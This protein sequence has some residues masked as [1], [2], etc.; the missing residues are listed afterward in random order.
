MNTIKLWYLKRYIKKKTFA[1]ANTLKMTIIIDMLFKLV[2]YLLSTPNFRKFKLYSQ[3]QSQLIDHIFKADTHLKVIY[4]IV[5]FFY[6]TLGNFCF[7]IPLLKVGVT[8]FQSLIEMH[9]L[10]SYSAKS[11]QSDSLESDEPI[12]SD[13]FDEIIVG[14]G[15]GGSI[16]ALEAIKVGRKTLLIELGSKIDPQISHQTLE[17]LVRYFLY[18]GQE[19]AFGNRLIAYAQ[20]SVLGGGSEINSGLYHKLPKKIMLRWLEGLNIES[21]AWTEAEK[22]I[23]KLL[24]VEEQDNSTLNC[25]ISSPFISIAKNNGWD[26]MLVPRWRHYGKKGFVHFGMNSAVLQASKA[27]GLKILT[28]HKVSKF[29]LVDNKVK[30]TLDHG[31]EIKILHASYLTIACG[32]TET[33]KLLIKSGFAKPRDFSFNFHAMTRL[34]ALFSRKV[35]DLKDIDPHQ[36]WKQDY[37]VKFGAAVGTKEFLAATLSNFHVKEEISQERALVAYAS[38]EPRGRGGFIKIGQVII[39]YF[40]F[41][42]RSLKEIDSNTELL[43]KSLLGAGAVKVLGSVRSPKISS[44]H[45]FGSLPLG[46]TRLLD[47]YGFLKD[48]GKKVRVCDGSLLPS[49]PLVNPQGPIGVLCLILSRR[50]NKKYW[51]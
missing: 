16:A 42:N 12:T 17:Q 34:V 32:T 10:I 50:V 38:T 4:L 20:G 9:S 21:S 7:K 43:R 25:Y 22:Y 49:A 35:N 26:Y 46:K 28:S 2:K 45:I 15:V 5:I 30:V 18:G 36:T 6:S 51:K 48:S 40:K 37:S 31:G 14:S 8:S 1:L 44:V 24:R 47:E 33:P 11:K 41:S 39:P 23:E 13:F 3:S 19:I 27:Q 29:E